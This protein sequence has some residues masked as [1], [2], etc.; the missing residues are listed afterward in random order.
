MIKNT[1]NSSGSRKES[2]HGDVFDREEPK[3]PCMY[4][5]NGSCSSMKESLAISETGV[6]FYE[7]TI[8]A[9]SFIINGLYDRIREYNMV[10]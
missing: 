7:V 8:D 2:L 9:A 4:P 10:S 5:T 3:S 6:K 1:Q